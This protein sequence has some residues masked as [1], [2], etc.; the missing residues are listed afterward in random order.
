M[1]QLELVGEESI[2]PLGMGF[3]IQE[4]LRAP[5]GPLADQ[6][7][8]ILGV[9]VQVLAI[10]FMLAL[11]IVGSFALT[12]RVLDATLV[13]GLW[14]VGLWN[15]TIVAPLIWLATRRH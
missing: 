12:W 13:N 11:A 9:L 1:A 14:V 2:H 3:P 6:V 8:A 7:I 5:K 10:R 15:L 4:P